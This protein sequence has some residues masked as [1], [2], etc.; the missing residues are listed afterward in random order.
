MPIEKRCAEL[1]PR[2]LAM[3][4][5]SDE[6]R[7]VKRDFNRCYDA[8]NG[9]YTRLSPTG[10]VEYWAEKCSPYRPFGHRSSYGYAFAREAPWL[11]IS[12]CASAVILMF[13]KC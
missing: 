4:T 8:G 6:V 9:P 3:G 5:S 1:V 13:A 2:G 11:A 12:Q 10:Y 7:L